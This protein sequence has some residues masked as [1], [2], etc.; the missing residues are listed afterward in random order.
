[1]YQTKLSAGLDIEL[2]ERMQCLH[3]HTLPKY[4]EEGFEEIAHDFGLVVL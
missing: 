3:D 4:W 2:L 1:M